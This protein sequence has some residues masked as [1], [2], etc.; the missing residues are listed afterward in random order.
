[1]RNFIVLGLAAAGLSGCSTNSETF[2][3]K[4]GKGVGCKSILA[5][6]K[7]VDQGSFGESPET[8][9]TVLPVLGS[10][11]NPTIQ[12]VETPLSDDMVINRIKEEHLRVWIAPHQDEQGNLHEG[13]IVHTVLKPGYWHIQGAL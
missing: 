11:H 5:V 1:M 9:G 2:D 12:Y 7:M 8:P 13:S 6:N 10:P 4:E 3:C